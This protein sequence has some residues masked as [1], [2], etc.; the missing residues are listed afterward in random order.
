MATT[1][2]LIN[3]YVDRVVAKDGKAY[4]TV[5]C[6]TVAPDEH[7]ARQLAMKHDPYGIDWTNDEEISCEPVRVFGDPAPMGYVAYE[8][9][10][11]N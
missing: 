10:E 8:A 6:M 9:I 3:R 7:Q 4:R 2:G 1:Y 5:T 11:E